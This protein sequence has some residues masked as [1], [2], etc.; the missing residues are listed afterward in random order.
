MNT[1]FWLYIVSAIL[2]FHLLVDGLGYIKYKQAMAGMAM[3]AKF[4][5][6]P[7]AVTTL[8][9][10][11]QQWQPVLSAVGSLKAV[12]GVTVSTDLAGIVS[13]IAFDSGR[14][15]K[16][17][18]LL[19]KLD[20]RQEDAALQQA[21]AKLEWAKISLDRQK[22]LLAKKVSAQA[23]F[24]S[25]NVEYRQDY[26]LVENAKALIARKTIVAPFDG[27]LGIRQV[28]LGQYLNVG[29]TIAPLQSL[30]PIFIDFSLPQQQ[31][32]QVV[33]GKK[34]RVRVDGVEGE[35][36]GEI[37][38]TDSLVDTSTRN[39]TVEATVQN[40]EMKL[41]PGMFGKVEVL[42]PPQDGVIAIPATSINYAPYGDSVFV[43]KKDT[44]KDGKPETIVEE[45]TVKVGANR[46][47]MV[48]VLSGVKE[49]DE[50]VTSGVFRLRGGA[51]VNINNSVQ[52]GNELN[53]KP[54]DT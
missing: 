6:P 25:A 11:P 50:V 45:H 42:L 32:S 49:G 26:A 2:A 48:S 39:I 29:S 35:F 31:L 4:A 52:P 13:D 1:K 7:T 15:V 24:D 46:G 27:E 34:I 9:A 23:D 18:D 40:P 36:D 43:I 22:D 16:K 38:S 53:P 3:A 51:A 33:V 41:R 10:K 54:P 44:G 5:P 19:V 12:N 47:D 21:E 30:D 8:V 28:N 20:T 14:G 17:G 37:T